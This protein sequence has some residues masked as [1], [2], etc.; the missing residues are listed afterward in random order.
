MK[1][2]NNPQGMLFFLSFL[3][4]VY[5][6]SEDY[7]LRRKHS[8]CELNE[9]Y[10]RLLDEAH[11]NTLMNTYRQHQESLALPQTL[12][13]FTFRG[14]CKSI[15]NINLMSILHG[16][17]VCVHSHYYGSFSLLWFWNICLLKHLKR[18]RLL[19]VVVIVYVILYDCLLVLN[20][21]NPEWRLLS[22]W[23]LCFD[24]FEN[25]QKRRRMILKTNP[26]LNDSTTTVLTK[27]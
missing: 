4:I 22:C 27:R 10:T 21:L 7:L 8:I 23:N 18:F 11:M 1:D 3:L 15:P 2:R 25:V 5:Y 12:L 9:A 13:E 14:A 24:D 17:G 19:G 20:V 6:L 26:A 16:L